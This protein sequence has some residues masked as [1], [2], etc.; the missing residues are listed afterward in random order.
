MDINKTRHIFLNSL[1]PLRSLTGAW[2]PSSFTQTQTLPTTIKSAIAFAIAGSLVYN[3][4]LE[5][6]I[7]I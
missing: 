4:N 5:L 2:S 6:P 1:F 3:L 7:G